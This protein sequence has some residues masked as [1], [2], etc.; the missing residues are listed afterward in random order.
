MLDDLSKMTPYLGSRFPRT[1]DRSIRFL[2]FYFDALEKVASDD[3][4][5]H[6]PKHPRHP[7]CEGILHYCTLAA[8]VVN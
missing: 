3:Y 8:S 4:I 7:S 5:E 2:Q 6:R 1:I